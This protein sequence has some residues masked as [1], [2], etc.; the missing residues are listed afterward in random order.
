MYDLLVKSGY[1]PETY[2]GRYMFGKKCLAFRFSGR[3]NNI[4]VSLFENFVPSDGLSR[5]EFLDLLTNMQFDEIGRD[6]IAY[7]PTLAY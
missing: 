5:A 4:F 2:S 6:S 1:E 3:V 7:F